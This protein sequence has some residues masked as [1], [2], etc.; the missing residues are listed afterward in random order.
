MLICRVMDRGL[1]ALNRVAQNA[2]NFASFVKASTLVLASESCVVHQVMTHHS[3]GSAY[4]FN[5]IES[6]I[7][8]VDG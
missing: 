4:L 5:S 7:I 6:V 1:A 3:S 2:S 8:I